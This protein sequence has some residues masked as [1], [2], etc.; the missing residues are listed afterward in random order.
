MVRNAASQKYQKFCGDHCVGAMDAFLLTFAPIAVGH[1]AVPP[2]SVF[3]GKEEPLNDFF[4]LL[5]EA[6]PMGMLTKQRVLSWTISSAD[7]GQLTSRHFSHVFVHANY[8]HMLG[9][10]VSALQCGYAVFDELG[11]ADMY[12][13]FFGGGAAA[14]LPSLLKL[15]QD[16]LMAESL[17]GLP[18]SATKLLPDWL[19]RPMRSGSD[20]LVGVVQQAISKVSY[21]CGSSGAVSA[22]MGCKLALMVTDFA[23]DVRRNWIVLRDFELREGGALVGGSNRQESW[24]RRVLSRTVKSFGSVIRS[25]GFGWRLLSALNVLRLLAVDARYLLGGGS[26]AALCREQPVN[27][28]RAAHLQGALFGALFGV[29][30]ALTRRSTE[31]GVRSLI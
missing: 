13:V 6:W 23:L 19:A 8:Q 15:E 10:L 9:N 18:A 11:V 14:A 2:L 1:C 5:Y 28:D 17:V 25:P 27:I 7:R 26:A 4:M 29:F 30:R 24:A 3:E 31:G 21:S 16:K 22:L 20:K 12:F